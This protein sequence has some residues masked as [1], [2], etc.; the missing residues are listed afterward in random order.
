MSESTNDTDNRYR[1]TSTGLI[2]APGILRWLRSV[3]QTDPQRSILI[4]ASTF[5]TLPIGTAI[6][7]LVGSIEA[8]LEDSGETAV[9]IQTNGYAAAEA[10]EGDDEDTQLF[11]HREV[12]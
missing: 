6:A 3:Y 1:L 12:W 5:P 8:E 2:H 4:T 11:T 7:Y 9:L 10:A